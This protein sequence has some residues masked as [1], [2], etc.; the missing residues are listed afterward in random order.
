M[1]IKLQKAIEIFV[2]LYLA[3]NETHILIV[4]DY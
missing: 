1:T 4:Y 2:D 3:K